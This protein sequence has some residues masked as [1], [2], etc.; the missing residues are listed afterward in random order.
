MTLYVYVSYKRNMYRITNLLLVL[1]ITLLFVLP[2]SAIMYASASP[3]NSDDDGGGGGDSSSSDN[4]DESDD[5][6][7]MD[8]NDDAMDTMSMDDESDAWSMEKSNN[9]LDSESMDNNDDAMDTMSMDDESDTMSMD[10]ESD[11]MSMDDESDTM[12]MKSNNALSSVVTSVATTPLNPFT[13]DALNPQSTG[14]PAVTNDALNPQST[15]GPAVTNKALRVES[16]STN[17]TVPTTSTASNNTGNESA[18]FV[19]AILGIHNRERAAV[20]A[21]GSV[22]ALVWNDKL[23]AGAKAWAEHLATT[24]LREHSPGVSENIAWGGTCYGYPGEPGFSCTPYTVVVMQ[25]GWVHEKVNWNGTYYK[26]ASQHECGHYTQM[27]EN[28][29]K[30]VGCGIASGPPSVRM[31]VLV[32]R[33]A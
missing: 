9:A 12:S 31:G 8:N 30:Q 32:C 5:S 3:Q 13:N 16:N 4:S 33:Y 14:G 28:A 19:N 20:N 23:A 6:G 24:G 1:I 27:I 15:G 10:D 22:P 18:D 11:T 29:H 21:S 17:S 2:T 26:C 7:S 25:E